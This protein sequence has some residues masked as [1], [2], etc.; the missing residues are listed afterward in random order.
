MITRLIRILIGVALGSGLLAGLILVLIH[1]LGD[2]EHLYKGKRLSYLFQQMDSADPALSNEVRVV[3]QT[4]A[5]PRLITVMF[6]DTND[7]TIRMTLVE[8]LNELPGVNIIADKAPMRRAIAAGTLGQFGPRADVAV[9][10]LVK[11]VK[12]HD[13]APR[14]A[15]TRALGQIHCQPDQIVPLLITCLDDSQDGVAE[16]AAVSLGEFGSLAKDA[17][18]KLVPWVNAQDKDKR[19]A[20]II[21]LPKI[22]SAAALQAGIK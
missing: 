17:V 16:A 9:P 4:E 7:S 22:D 20:A 18:P 15:A 12:G 19:H 6:N 13:A 21:A 3:L 1:S 10:S 14:E 8:N 2:P 11:V 5:I